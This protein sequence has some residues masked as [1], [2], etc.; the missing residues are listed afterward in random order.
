MP[1]W[2][3]AVRKFIAIFVLFSN[4]LENEIATKGAAALSVDDCKI[5]ILLYADDCLLLSE[6]RNGLQQGINI[7][8]KFW[9]LKIN[10]EKTKVI[11]FRRAVST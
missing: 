10:T 1:Y 2:C 4:D 8:H 7:L 5:F 9:R 11:I 3:E 6:A